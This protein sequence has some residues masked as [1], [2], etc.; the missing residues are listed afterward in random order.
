MPNPLF[1]GVRL[2]LTD[3]PVT[4]EEGIVEDDAPS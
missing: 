2:V 3:E 1:S 4:D